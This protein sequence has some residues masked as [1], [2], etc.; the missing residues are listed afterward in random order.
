M[1]ESQIVNFGDAYSDKTLQSLKVSFRKLAAS[2]TLTAKYRVDGA[3]A[4]TTIGTFTTTSELSRTFINIEASDT[5]FASGKEYEFR[6]ESTGGLE[7]TGWKARAII[8]D[9]V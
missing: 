9:T 7:I 1:Y 6:L 2:E 8:N 4:W 3:T 5:A